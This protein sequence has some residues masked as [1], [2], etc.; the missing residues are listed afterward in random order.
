MLSPDETRLLERLT[1]GG[2]ANA[3]ASSAGIRRART[4][5]PGLEFHEYRRYQPGDDPRSIDWTVEA[6]LHQL[7]VRV[8]R[9][10]G[11]LRLH[12]L[13]DTSAS[14]AIGTP[15]KLSC[16]TRLGAALCYAAVERRDAVGISTFDGALRTFM[17]PAAGRRQLF[18]ALDA[19]LSMDAHGIS[20]IN[21]ALLQYG[22]ATRGPGVVAVLSDFFEPGAGIEGLRYLLHRGLTPA[23]V[24]IV[25]DEELDPELDEYAELVDV[26]D[27]KGRFV[28]DRTAIVGY[29][30]RLHQQQ[31]TLH[32]FSAEH[33]LCFMRLASSTSF[34]AMVTAAEAAGLFVAAV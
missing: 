5:G 32:A 4:R 23:V 26:E 12:V 1:I 27:G 6:R 34:G 10:E 17:P 13:V 25:A 2:T 11:D 21:R 3:V 22:T 24:Q 31:S 28:V 9:A 7:V 8:A 19:L 18:R 14:M 16:A 15:S 20:A 29:R 30:A 33:G